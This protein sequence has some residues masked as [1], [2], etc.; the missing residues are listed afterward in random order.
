MYN[1]KKGLVNLSKKNLSKRKRKSNAEVKRQRKRAR[2]KYFRKGDCFTKE[3]IY[4]RNFLYFTTEDT[5]FIAVKIRD[6]PKLL[7]TLEKKFVMKSFKVL[8]NIFPEFAYK[9]EEE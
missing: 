4:Q 1:E 3:E 5:H 7:L 9:S 2:L 6:Y 8:A